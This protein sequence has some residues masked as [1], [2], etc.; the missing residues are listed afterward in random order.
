M[1]CYKCGFQLP[2]GSFFCPKCGTQV[3]QPNDPP[4]PAA[5]APQPV[6][7]T[8]QPY[9]A[10]PQPVAA[11]PQQAFGVTYNTPG[12]KLLRTNRGMVKYFLLSII[13]LGIYG[14]VVMCHL[15]EEINQVASPRDG[16]HTMHY[17]LVAFIFSGLTLG[18]VPLVWMSRLTGRIGDEINARNLPKIISK[19]TFWGWGF[20]GSLIVVGPFIYYYKLFKA[21]NA[22]AQDYNTGKS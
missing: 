10:P 8:P 1:F 22:I 18:I 2:E 6:M 19:G 17:A 13:T 12:G 20:F 3:A 16:K 14:L 4:Q 11:P 7:A 5:V 21:T 15:S 9:M